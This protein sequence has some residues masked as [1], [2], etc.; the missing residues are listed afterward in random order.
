M[1]IDATQATQRDHLFISYAWED[2]ALAEWLTLK[3]TA[4]G[5][6]VWCDRFKILGGEKWPDDVDVA[7]R[8][9]TFRLLHLVSKHSLRKP[10]PKK[11]RELVLQLEKERGTEILVP[12]NVDGTK[13]SELPWRIVDV[14]Y[15]PFRNWAAGFAQLLKK[16]R[17]INAPRPLQ[18][19]GREIAG[20][21]YLVRSPVTNSAETLISNIY[22]FT[23]VPGAIKR[24]TFSELGRMRASTLHDTWAFRDLGGEAALAFATPSAPLV[25]KP[26]AQ[27]PATLVWHEGEIV[28]GI[29]A[30]H[31]VTELLAKSLGL[32]CLSR[33]LVAEPNGRRFYFPFGLLPRNTIFF[34]HVDQRRTRVLVCGQR[35]FRFRDYRYHLS[36]GFRVR[37]DR[38][39]GFVAQLRLGLYLTDLKRVPLA[40]RAAVARR[41]KIGSAWWNSQWLSRQLAVMSF[42]ANGQPEIVVGQDPKSRVIL[43]SSP[44]QMPID[45][46]IDEALLASIGA[47]VGLPMP[48]VDEEDV[49]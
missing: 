46:G 26:S 33:G 23:S 42:L 2:G 49:P 24:F 4:E 28:E 1:S 11:E 12:L 18:P 40:R 10:N 47:P 13:P 43:R 9:K 45:H 41:K 3:L 30:E 31:L 44:L 21:A 34:E 14:A 39:L 17:S 36:A 16:L 8:D 5:Y 22:P 15:I 37:R 6:R 25:E 38:D 7:I 29:L 48:A 20:S 35:Q 32:H 27:E 19:T